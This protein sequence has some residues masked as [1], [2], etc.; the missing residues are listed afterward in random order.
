[1]PA[2][3][4]PGQETGEDD[5]RLQVRWPVAPGLAETALDGLKVAAEPASLYRSH[6]QDGGAATQQ[7]QR[8]DRGDGPRGDHHQ[9]DRHRDPAMAISAPAVMREILPAG[10]LASI[11][12][13]SITVSASAVTGKVHRVG[14]GVGRHSAGWM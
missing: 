8:G 5:G 14:V 7:L 10:R 11:T 13:T 4:A 3:V 12:T 2:L 6:T 9:I 1:M